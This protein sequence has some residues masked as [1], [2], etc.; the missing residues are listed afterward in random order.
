MSRHAEL[1]TAGL[2]HASS[3]IAVVKCRLAASGTVILELV[4]LKD[5]ALPYL[6]ATH[7]ALTIVP[8]LPLPDRSVTVVPEPS[9]NEKAMTSSG[10]VDSVVTVTTLEYGPRLLAAS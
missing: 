3:V 10:I 2:P 8:V 5:N 1:T 9:S 6:P 7:V 4:P